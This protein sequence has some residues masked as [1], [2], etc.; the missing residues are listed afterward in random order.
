M[1][2]FDT[3]KSLITEARNMSAA[4]AREVIRNAVDNAD[5]RTL[6]NLLRAVERPVLEAKSKELFAARKL[7]NFAQRNSTPFV[8]FVN[9]VSSAK[10]DTE[11]KIDFIQGCI[12][13]RYFNAKRFT[14]AKSGN[15]SAYINAT[16]SIMKQ[17]Y[18]WFLRWKPQIDENGTVAV[19]QM[20]AVMIFL[21]ADGGKGGDGDT[22]GDAFAGGQLI[23]VKTGGGHLG[24]SGKNMWG[25]AKTW[26]INECKKQIPDWASSKSDKDILAAFTGT[27]K[28]KNAVILEINEALKKA[29]KKPKDFWQ[30]F[31]V[32]IYGQKINDQG[33]LTDPNFIDLSAYATGLGFITYKQQTNFDMVSLISTKNAGGQKFGDFVNWHTPDDVISTFKSNLWNMDY[34]LGW[35]GGGR[36]DGLSP[37]LYTGSK[38]YTL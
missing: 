27:G 37:R 24:K 7:N 28:T 12:E 19:G 20:E 29:R 1:I 16:D 33:I 30:S 3:F 35:E 34:S 25:G 8:E 10:G 38:G 32:Q 11:E 9:K 22:F 13:G 36:V 23:E 5:G 17:L 2:N 21:A 6:I 4:Q 31:F 26:F 15:Y 14:S 18:S